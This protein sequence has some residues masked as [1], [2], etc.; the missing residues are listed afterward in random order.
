MQIICCDIILHDPLFYATRETG[1]LYETGRYIHNYA[2]SYA[3]GLVHSAYFH[4]QQVPHY[5]ED[6]ALLRE[7]QIYVTPALPQAINFQLATIKYGDELSHSEM[8]QGRVNTPS[9]GKLKEIAPESTFRCYVLS[10]RPITLPRWIRLGKWHSKALV[11]TKSVDNSV[12]SGEYLAACPLNPLDTP[13]GV[14]R[15]FDIISMPPASIVA[16]ARCSG[17]YFELERGIGLPIGMQ[18]TFPA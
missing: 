8:V 17:P 9:F 13:S 18:Y 14:L 2:L 7:Q 10:A 4:A 5:A 11:E 16:H 6:L 15:A 3:F 1:R 12:R